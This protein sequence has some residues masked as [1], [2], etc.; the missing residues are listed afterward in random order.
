MADSAGPRRNQRLN[1]VCIVVDTLRYDVV[2]H[3]YPGAEVRIP[4]L[5]ALRAQSIDMTAAF[6]EGEPTIP[7]RRALW[8]GIRS[9]P[10]RFHEDN[11][12]LWP[13]P[14]GWHRI[15][16]GQPTFAET[17][18]AQGYRTALISD[19]YH[20]FK[21]T[22]NFSRGW[23]SWE[24]VRGQETDNW[25]SG[26]LDTIRAEAAKFKKGE[27]DPIRDHAL[28]QYLFNRREFT[29]NDPLTTGTVFRSAMDWLGENHEEAPFALWLEAFDPHEP[30][31]P[32]REYADLYCPDFEGTE[33]IYP[34]EAARVGSEREQ[35]RA[36]ALY[37][38]EVTYVDEWIGKLMGRLSDLGRLDDTVVVF[39]S[40]HGTEL[41]DNGRFGK[42]ERQLHP[43]NTQ[44]NWMVRHPDLP[45]GRMV[46]D[47]ASSHDVFATL[48]D[49]LEIPEPERRPDDQRYAGRSMLPAIRAAAGNTSAAPPAGREFA[50]TGWAD[51]AAVRSAGWN[52]TVNVEQPDDNPRLY[53]LS[54]DPLETHNVVD[55]YA[56][57]AAKHRQALEELLG[58]ALPVVL[59]RPDHHP[60]PARA[61]YEARANRE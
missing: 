10:W 56:E 32:P 3:T 14:H 12:G 16:E 51:H 27:L 6:G 43:Y 40:D 33:F 61:Y 28:V 2:H 35:E 29:R 18:T 20:M 7:V 25:R 55:S 58:A 15:P 30:W 24:F 45:G 38:G 44:L 19:V 39:F 52:Y 49:A 47:F 41:M 5:D 11:E 60:T 50:I 21:P 31:D 34:P 48:L 8:T 46:N 26:S 37:L 36:R 17:L 23:L 57:V 22:M 9:Y 59:P 1:L 54:A 53:D 42:S 13:N 4:N